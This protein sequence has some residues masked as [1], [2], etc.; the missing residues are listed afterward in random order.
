MRVLNPLGINAVC[1]KPGWPLMLLGTVGGALMTPM[2]VL[3]FGVQPPAAVSND[4]VVT[5][6]RSPGSLSVLPATPAELQALHQRHRP[7]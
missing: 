1:G 7:L 6:G 4:L 2:L 5:A 3:F